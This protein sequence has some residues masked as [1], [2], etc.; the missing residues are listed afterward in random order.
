LTQELTRAL[1]QLEVALEQMAPSKGHW[2][3]DLVFMGYVL[4]ILDNGRAVA[5]LGGQQPPLHAT[6]AARSAFEAAQNLL[7]LV[8]SES[9]RAAGALAYVYG[10]RK[11]LELTHSYPAGMSVPTP[12]AG[13]PEWFEAALLEIGE[14]WE[15]LAPGSKALV[16]VANTELSARRNRKPDNWHGLNPATELAARFERNPLLKSHGGYDPAAAFRNVYRA[17]CRDTHP[18]TIVRPRG[19]TVSNAGM[20][21]T[22]LERRRPADT[23]LVATQTA[24]SSTILGL[25]AYRVRLSIADA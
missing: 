24:V 13:G 17:L 6:P 1:D 18:R 16:D 9:Y 3:P 15:A 25:T 12:D 10:L 20:L 21:H 8:S 19:I 23:I 22:D 11:D 4:E 7:M 5:R 2:V 14:T